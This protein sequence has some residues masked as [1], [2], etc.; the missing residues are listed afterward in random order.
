M[1]IPL[2]KTVSRDKFLRNM[3]IQKS[4]TLPQSDDNWKLLVTLNQTKRKF[5]LLS[6]LGKFQNMAHLILRLRN[7]FSATSSI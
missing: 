3:T 2:Y 5:T 1:A 4:V 7:R 6:A